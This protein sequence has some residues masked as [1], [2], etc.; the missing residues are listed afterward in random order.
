MNNVIYMIK[1]NIFYF[2]AAFFLLLLFFALFIFFLTRN[3]Q[4]ESAPEPLA[5]PTLVPVD[6]KAYPTG[7]EDP[8]KGTGLEESKIPSIEEKENRSYLVMSLTQK[9]PFQGL[10]F[11][12]SYDYDRGVFLLIY[13]RANLQQGQENFNAFLKENG[14]KDSLWIENIIISYQ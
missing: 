6:T 14:I 10:Y 8:K 4:P 2:L 1:N 12:L 13:N 11:S 3:V 7:S 5:T 9:L